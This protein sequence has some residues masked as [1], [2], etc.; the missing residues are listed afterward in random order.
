MWTVLLSLAFAAKPAPD[1]AGFY[2]PNDIAQASE[3]MAAASETM[4]SVADER[5][6]T[7]RKLATALQHYRE[8]LEL[9]GVRA[10]ATDW[11][12]LDELETRFHREEATLQGFADDLVGNFDQAMVDAMDRALAS[13]EGAV[14]CEATIPVEGG[15]RVP[16]MA[17]R[18]KPNP[19]CTGPNLNADIAAAMDA[20][21]ELGAALDEIL[22]QD[23]PV[24]T[25][26]P[27]AMAPA[28]EGM[29]GR[30]VSVRAW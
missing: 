29:G 9:L 18:S 11:A 30:Y 15:P 28:G 27:T 26:E 7:L 14:R 2:H 13:H 10:P 16:G 25:V 24:I 1:G 12:R 22:G 23:W 6:R 21:E 17:P 8:S 5:S 3:R 20:D 4:T 19:D